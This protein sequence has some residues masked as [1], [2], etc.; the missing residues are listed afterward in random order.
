MFSGIQFKSSGQTSIHLNYEFKRIAEESIFCFFA[1]WT[2][3][4]NLGISV[5]EYRLSQAKVGIFNVAQIIFT[6]KD[7]DMEFSNGAHITINVHSRHRQ[8]SGAITSCFPITTYYIISFYKAGW[9]L[10]IAKYLQD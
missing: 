8:V 1:V 6:L 2:L 10:V 5:I 3:D 9:W 4:G 7:D